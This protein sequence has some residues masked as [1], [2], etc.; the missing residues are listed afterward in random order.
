MYKNQ[1]YISKTFDILLENNIDLSL[2]K[3]NFTKQ[4][5]EENLLKSYHRQ[6]LLYFINGIIILCFS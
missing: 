3:I 6:T 1:I 4:I 5:L 2:C